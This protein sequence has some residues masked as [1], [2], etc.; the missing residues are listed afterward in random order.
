MGSQRATSSNGINENHQASMVHA[1]L[2]AGI[3]KAGFC[4]A[5]MFIQEMPARAY[6]NDFHARAVISPARKHVCILCCWMLLEHPVPTFGNQ[7]TQWQTPLDACFLDISEEPEINSDLGRP[8]I[9]LWVSCVKHAE[10]R[11]EW[12]KMTQEDPRWS[13]RLPSWE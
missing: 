4:K 9:Q 3:W 7:I 6:A 13:K 2:D 1:Q 10:K 11:H 12:S 5:S 8:G